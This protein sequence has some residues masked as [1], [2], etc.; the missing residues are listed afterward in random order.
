MEFGT[1]VFAELDDVEPLVWQS[2][3]KL[4]ARALIYDADEINKMVWIIIS[5]A[6]ADSPVIQRLT[7]NGT[8]CLLNRH[9]QRTLESGDCR[10]NMP[11][12][13]T[14]FWMKKSEILNNKCPTLPG[15]PFGALQPPFC[16]HVGVL[17]RRLPLYAFYLCSMLR[18]PL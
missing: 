10:V 2:L 12:C 15:D 14:S 7:T 16:T 3:P 17:H 6:I 5:V 4:Q 8:P 13:I 9:S 11:T 18:R 1:S